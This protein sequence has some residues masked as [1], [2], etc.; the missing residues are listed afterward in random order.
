MSGKDPSGCIEIAL[1]VSENEFSFK[2]TDDGRGIQVDKLRKKALESGI[3][4]KKEIEKWN[5]KEVAETIFY[6]GIS[7]LDKANLVAGRGIGMDSVK[8]KVVNAGG[9]ILINFEPGKFCE[10]EIMVPIQHGKKVNSENEMI[11]VK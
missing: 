5:D 3:W 10:F 11:E 2:L 9:E 6:T 7:T 1:D 4:N 8:E